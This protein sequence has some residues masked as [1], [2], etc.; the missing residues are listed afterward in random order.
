MP[1]R[2]KHAHDRL[3]QSRHGGTSARRGIPLHNRGPRNDRSSS[4]V[5]DTNGIQSTRD[6]VRFPVSGKEIRAPQLWHTRANAGIH[7]Y[8]TG[9]SLSLRPVISNTPWRCDNLPVCLCIRI[10]CP[11]CARRRGVLHYDTDVLGMTALDRLLHFSWGTCTRATLKSISLI[12]H[13]AWG[14]FVI[15]SQGQPALHS[16][17]AAQFSP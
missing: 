15:C 10:E 4:I 2:E 11:R 7:D 6:T 1:E 17:S 12:S 16:V 13:Q 8:A 9:P 14:L 5:R 3:A